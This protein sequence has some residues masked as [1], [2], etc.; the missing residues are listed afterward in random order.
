MSRQVRI[1]YSPDL[2][3]IGQ[4]RELEDSEAAAL[5]AD[6]RAAYVEDQSALAERPK[7]ELL[8]QAN[9]LGLDVSERD[10]RASLAQAIT[11]AES[12]QG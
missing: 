11:R 5:V 2:T 7:A 9:R 12:G 10:S 8:D 4:V 1:S 6:G 3:Q